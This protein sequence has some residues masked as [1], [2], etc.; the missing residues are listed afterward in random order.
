MNRPKTRT[1]NIVAQET[2]KEILIYDLKED[3]AY[4]LNET[5]AMIYQ[6]CDGK[7]SVAEIANL[8]SVKLN[9]L[10]SEDLIWLALDNFK[11]DNLLEHE[12]NFEIDFNG[13]NRRQVIKK[14]GFASM[15]ALPVVAS[16]IA[17]TAAMAASA[18]ILLGA[19]CP[20]GSGCDIGLQCRSLNTGGNFCCVPGIPSSQTFQPGI[21]ICNSSCANNPGICCSG[22]QVPAPPAQFCAPFGL[23]TCTCS[24]YP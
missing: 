23:V 13:L 4:C 24:P 19:A 18:A 10:V 11:K 12:E 16:V 8:M 21:P 5:S 9:K 20:T 1:E 22:T 14:V 2:E 6:L 15:I 3:K 17:P 7:N